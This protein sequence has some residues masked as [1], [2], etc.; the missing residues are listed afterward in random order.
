[1][2]AA[3]K[4]NLDGVAWKFCRVFTGTHSLMS[5]KRVAVLLFLNESLDPIQVSK[6]DQEWRR[7][8]DYFFS[9]SCIHAS[10]HLTLDLFLCFPKRILLKTL[11][12]N[13]DSHLRMCPFFVDI[14]PS[15]GGAAS[16]RGSGVPPLDGQQHLQRALPH[17]GAGG[18]SDAG[19]VVLRP[20]AVQ[21]ATRGGVALHLC[22]RCQ[23]QRHAREGVCAFLVSERSGHIISSTSVVLRNTL[24]LR[25]FT[26]VLLLRNVL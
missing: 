11:I 26:I 9:E 10:T 8:T 1:M 24:K 7:E 17:P 15:G 3:T 14:T 19:R 5:S 21:E 20:L 2:T 22:C 23:R 25:R 6:E 16:T 12:P 18:G 4:A 13:G